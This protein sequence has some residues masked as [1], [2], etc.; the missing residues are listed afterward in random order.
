MVVVHEHSNRSVAG[1]A[2]EHLHLERPRR[3]TVAIASHDQPT[4]RQVVL[5]KPLH[6]VPS[7]AFG[8]A[9]EVDDVVV[10][11][12][13]LRNRKTFIDRQVV[14]RGSEKGFPVLGTVL[15]VVQPMAYVRDNAVQ[16]D[17]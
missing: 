14:G 10:L 11:G 2:F 17:G 3:S 7:T 15:D 12:E 5:R 16:V 9:G 4:G 6:R 8:T 13:P 1:K